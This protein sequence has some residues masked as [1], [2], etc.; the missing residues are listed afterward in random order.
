MFAKNR[1]ILLDDTFSALDGETERHVFA[2]LLGSNGI[3]RR[4]GITIV[5]V[6][7]SGKFALMKPV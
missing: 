7:S 4:H 3:L 2:N 1:I 6:S 5:L